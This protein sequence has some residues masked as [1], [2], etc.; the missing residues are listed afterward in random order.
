MSIPSTNHRGL[1]LFSAPVTG[2]GGGEATGK[3]ESLYFDISNHI[4]Q[5]EA[6]VSLLFFTDRLHTRG[7]VWGSKGPQIATGKKGVGYY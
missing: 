2:R 1:V 3:T 6:S 5:S 4:S 7:V